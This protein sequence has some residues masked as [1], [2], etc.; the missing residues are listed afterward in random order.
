MSEIERPERFRITP[1]QRMSPLWMD[2]SAFLRDRLESLRVQNDNLN[3]TPEKTQVL[4]GRIAE[5]N[6]ILGLS[7]DKPKVPPG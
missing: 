4:R 7:E 1:A 3:L 5:L 2:L 6:M